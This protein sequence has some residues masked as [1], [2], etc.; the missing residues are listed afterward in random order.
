MRDCNALSFS[1][2]NNEVKPEIIFEDENF[3]SNSIFS[4]SSST[5][6]IEEKHSSQINFSD[7]VSFFLQA[8]QNL[9]KKKSIY[10]VR[11]KIMI[12]SNSN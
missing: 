10:D 1:N 4:L 2:M 11:S 8:G 12:S 3:R 7:S 5:L 6:F 9:G